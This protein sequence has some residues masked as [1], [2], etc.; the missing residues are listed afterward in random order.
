MKNINLNSLLETIAEN[1]RERCY[2]LAEPTITVN[3]YQTFN[4]NLSFAN[5]K[6]LPEYERRCPF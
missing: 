4:Y 5:D 3:V 2:N 1:E 6:E